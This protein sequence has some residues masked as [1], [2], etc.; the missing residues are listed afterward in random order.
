MVINSP[1]LIDKK[2][3]AS[4]GQTKVN[5]AK[6]TLTTASSKLMLHYGI[7]HHLSSYK[8][9]IQFLKHKPKRKHTKKPEV[10]P[11]ESSAEH[12]LPS[13]SHD[14]LPSGEDSLKHKE[15][16]D[17]YTSLSNKV[18]DLESEVP[19][20]ES[21]AEH[22]VSLPSPSHDTLPSGEDNVNDKEPAGVKEVL[23]VVKAAKLITEVVTTAGVDVNATSVQD[24]PITVVEAT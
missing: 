10:P 21:Q 15:L 23:E 19:P 3:L 6:Q 5:T 20:S 2:E 7:C 8:S 1:C 18:L 4:P 22:N 11:T 14:P 17:F 13:P 24:T 16:M 12:N 9:E